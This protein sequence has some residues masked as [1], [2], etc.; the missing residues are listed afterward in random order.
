MKKGHV[1]HKASGLCMTTTNT[2]YKTPITLEECTPKGKD[3][4][5]RITKEETH[6]GEKGLFGIESYLKDNAKDN[7]LDVPGFSGAKGL[8]AQMCGCQLHTKDNM[9]YRLIAKK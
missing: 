9:L 5:W 3:Q 4:K 2:D 7:C 1:I 6:K 8:K